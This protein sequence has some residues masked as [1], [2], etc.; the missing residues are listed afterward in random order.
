L[1]IELTLSGLC[2]LV[3][4][5]LFNGSSTQKSMDFHRISS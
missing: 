5:Q 2:T 3:D 1:K 4:V